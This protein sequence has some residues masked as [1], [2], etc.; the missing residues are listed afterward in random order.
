M[1]S[2]GLATAITNY[3]RDKFPGGEGQAQEPAQL[4]TIDGI[5]WRIKK[6]LSN[7]SARAWL[8]KLGWN[9]KEVC[10]EIYKDGH[11]RP[12]VQEYRQNIFLPRMASFKSRM[13]EWD[14]DL[15]PIIK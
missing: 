6:A 10:K 9:W 8:A 5:Q 7:R 3:W 4:Y 12:D 13:M 14:D 15:Q 1:D 11:E 2:I